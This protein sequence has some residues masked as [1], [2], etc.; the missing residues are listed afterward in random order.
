[1]RLKLTITLFI[2]NVL[3]FGLIYYLD[4]K[5]DVELSSD[6]NALLL[7]VDVEAIERIDIG[8]PSL[9]ESRA[10]V[11]SETGRTWFLTEPITWPANLFAVTRILNQLQFLEE[12]I[13]FSLDEIEEAGQGLADYGLDPPQ[14]T[15][16]LTT[17]D[18]EESFYMGA[19]TEM[20]NR[21]Y[22]MGPER[23]RVHVANR[24]VLETLIVPID[25]LRNPQIFE[26]PVFEVRSLTMRITSPGDV[27]IRLAREGETWRF[28]TPLVAAA[29]PTLVNTTIKELTSVEAL[30]FYNADE[31]DPNVTGL[32][33]P[34]RRV[35]LEGNGR[36][37]TLLIGNETGTANGI[38]KYFAQLENNPTIV[39]VPAAPFDSLFEAQQNL[40]DTT[41][42]S[43]NPDSIN[44][45]LISHADRQLSLQKLETGSW[46]VL[47]SGT[48]GLLSTAAA[49]PEL[50]FDLLSGLQRLE[51]KMFVTDV[52]TQEALAG[53]Y[54][55]ADPQWTLKVSGAEG[56]ESLEI[57]EFFRSEEG[58]ILI[59]ARKSLM[60]TIYGI[61]RE[62][63][64]WL[65]I[66]SLHYRNRDLRTLPKGAKINSIRLVRLPEEEVFNLTLDTETDS[67]TTVLD[68]TTR[69]EEE[70][71]A[72]LD[73]VGLARTFRV[74]EYVRDS[75]TEN[76]L[77]EENKIIPWTYRFELE[78][79]LPG[80]GTVE[81]REETYFFTERL[82]GSFQAAGS[83]DLGIVFSLSPDMVNALFPFVF[84][85]EKPEDYI[86]PEP[87]PKVD[88]PD[89]AL[90]EG[91]TV[92]A[93]PEEVPA[94]TGNT[95]P[96]SP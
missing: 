66:D 42:F 71:E 53:E 27:T 49:D 89:P 29:D 5:A 51:A 43:F 33:T 61:D 40:R 39:V 28:E 69:T 50:L 13:S 23:D 9:S 19:S 25:D 70:K 3:A 63:L 58:P 87:V 16:K 90:S 62:I 21:L 4:K 77:E 37:Q 94:D 10:L 64:R 52:P 73:L 35:T 57:G 20:G 83:P 22:L 95:E 85:R 45:I 7:Q 18:K 48:D 96:T 79:A 24:E 38:K 6:Q 68:N 15:L 36:R 11:K 2:L 44:T 26:I 91:G 47:Q 34:P 72:L 31:L 17:E 8:G 80:G 1:M 88:T 86:R 60:N 54:G 41:I 75:F 59:Y 78:I 93:S 46:Q 76:Y 55:L 84:T 82:S 67:W 32:L 65:R 56:E 81:T 74:S 30:D 14:L 12:E 92:N